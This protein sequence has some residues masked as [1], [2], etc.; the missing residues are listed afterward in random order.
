MNKK[1]Y[2]NGEVT[3]TWEPEKCT[4]SGNCVKGLS[5]VFRPKEKPWIKIDAASTNDLVEQVRKCPSG[6]LGYYF[7]EK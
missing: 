5:K 3:V 6:A 2:P 1:E 4:H 7:E